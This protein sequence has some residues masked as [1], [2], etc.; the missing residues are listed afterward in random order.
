MTHACREYS[1]SLFYRTHSGPK[2]HKHQEPAPL[3]DI[4]DCV[5]MMI[6]R[7]ANADSKEAIAEDWAE[8]AMTLDR[9]FLCLFSCFTFGTIVLIFQRAVF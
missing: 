5:D 7:N 6:Q 3:S 8:V 4:K 9:I 2:E 1:I